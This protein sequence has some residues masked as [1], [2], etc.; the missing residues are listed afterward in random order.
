MSKL[1]FPL[2]VRLYRKDYGLC[3]KGFEGL[4][5]LLVYDFFSILLTECF[6]QNLV[7][8]A[9]LIGWQKNVIRFCRL[10]LG[11]FGHYLFAIVF[12]NDIIMS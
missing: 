7:F 9:S 10:P 8:S 12:V 2:S 5:C 3:K 6:L 1:Q 11:S 4:F